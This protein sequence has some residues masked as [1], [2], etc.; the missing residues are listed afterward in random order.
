M[1]VA[2][3]VLAL[4]S[5]VVWGLI[6]VRAYD[7]ATNMHISVCGDG[8]VQPDEVCDAG[9]GHNNGGYASSI[10]TRTCMPGCK[11]FGPYCGDGVLQAQYGEQCDDGNNVSGDLCSATCQSET[12]VPPAGSGRPTVGSIPSESAPPGGISSALVTKV[13]LQGTAYPLA[14]VDIL[15]DGVKL[16]TVNADANAD[17][18][19]SSTDITPGTI[20]FSFLATD[21]TGVKSSLTSATFAVLQSAVTTVS[22]IFIP[23]SISLSSIQLNPG[24]L[25]T[26]SGQSVPN[27]TV[28]TQITGAASSTFGATVDASGAW[29]LQ[30]DTGSLPLGFHAAKSYDQISDSEKSGYGT[31]VNFLIGAGSGGCTV[32]TDLNNDHKVN[33]VDFSIFLTDWN[34]AAP[35]SDFN[36]DGTVNLADF[37]I[38]LFHW[39]G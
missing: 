6:S 25:L 38:L 12:A 30:V 11:A 14:P 8:I 29:A 23:P 19:Y 21:N 20:T 36:C 26:L 37:S 22:N 27:T 5:A 1:S 9:A 17:F 13:V 24:D 34:S 28:V 18:L 16:V 2:I 4:G 31:A 35:R 33:L 15:M 32:T 3:F 10:A 7:I 39:T